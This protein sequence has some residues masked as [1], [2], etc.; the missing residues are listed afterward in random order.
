MCN[1]KPEPGT[2]TEKYAP[3]F[4]I[5]KPRFSSLAVIA[6]CC[7]LGAIVCIALGFFLP[8]STVG[9]AMMLAMVLFLLCPV[10]AIAATLR[11]SKSGGR[12]RGM[13]LVNASFILFFIL[14]LFAI[15]MPA[16]ERPRD[17][18]WVSRKIVCMRNL[19]SL[20]QGIWV[21]ALENED[22]LPVGSE[23][24]DLIRD[25][26]SDDTRYRC[27]L[28]KEGA[29]SFAINQNLPARFKDVPDD[30]VVLF[31]SNTGWNQVGGLD[32][33]VTDR[34]D[35]PG[36]TVFF[37]DGHVEFVRSEDISGLRWKGD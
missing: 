22:L 33:V 5:A 7:G 13:G 3:D 15:L 6:L 31:E 8:G 34:H 2:E 20:G 27:P 11:I 36:C 19:R 29:C 37:A 21:Y 28:D 24:C 23:W 32:S 1:S 26:L 17:G 9:G 14:M 4:E 12:L 30:M 16:L 18:G 35:K 25:S 10:F